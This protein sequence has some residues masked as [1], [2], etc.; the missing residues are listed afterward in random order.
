MICKVILKVFFL[1]KNFDTCFGGPVGMHKRILKKILGS[2][3]LTD[4]QLC[5]LL[6]FKELEMCNYLSGSTRFVGHKL[7][8]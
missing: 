6:Q 7:S 3:I 4:P 2:E 8:F 1:K 5:M